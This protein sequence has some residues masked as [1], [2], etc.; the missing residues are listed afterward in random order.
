MTKILQV[1]TIEAVQITDMRGN[2]ITSANAGKKIK[3]STTTTI[4]TGMGV[5]LGVGIW[6]DVDGGTF[7]FTDGANVEIPRLP[8]SDSKAVTDLIG[9]LPTGRMDLF[10][11]L[12]IVTENTTGIVMAVYTFEPA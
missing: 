5:L 10:N 9:T 3:S 6:K 1:P 2:P 12:K 8:F 11:G 4:F 7:Y